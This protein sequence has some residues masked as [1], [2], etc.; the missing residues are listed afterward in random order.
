[1]VV[2][3]NMVWSRDPNDGE[4]RFPVLEAKRSKND[5]R[6]PGTRTIS[7]TAFSAISKMRDTDEFNRVRVGFGT[8]EWPCGADLDPE[9]VWEKSIPI[10][11]NK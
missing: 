10:E 2:E 4:R 3:E 11:R 5:V 1:M 6:S 9:F 8:I 7:E